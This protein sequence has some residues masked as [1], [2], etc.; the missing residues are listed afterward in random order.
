MSE[1][2]FEGLSAWALRGGP[3]RPLAI[4]AAA[5]AVTVLLGLALSGLFAWLGGGDS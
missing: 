5:F 4:V 3:W 1:S 2:L